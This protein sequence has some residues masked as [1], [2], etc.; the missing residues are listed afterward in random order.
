MLK[1]NRR[2]VFLKTLAVLGRLSLIAALAWVA[3]V[4]IEDRQALNYLD[5]LNRQISEERP[6]IETLESELKAIREDSR[7]RAEH[8]QILR[9]MASLRRNLK[10]P[11]Y[12]EHLNYVHGRGITLRGGAPSSRLVLEMTDK[13]AMD[14]LWK[15]L[16]VTQ[17]RS[18]E[19]NR[20]NQVHFV[21]EG[22]LD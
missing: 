7:E 16:R 19:V 1:R 21:I 6:G 20:V 12:L 11:I 4:M 13:L 2:R 15:G 18:E 17:L 22:Q 14:P 5:G 10:K 3:F 8:A 9:A